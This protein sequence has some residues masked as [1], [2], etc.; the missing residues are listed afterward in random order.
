MSSA[1]TE[2]ALKISDPQKRAMR[3]LL[4]EKVEYTV[5]GSKAVDWPKQWKFSIATL[6]ELKEMQLADY[7]ILASCT[8]T[9][10]LTTEGKNLC[11]RLRLS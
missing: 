6:R 10:Q 7:L 3:T 11:E 9:W 8:R 4:Q 5:H 1:S 2:D